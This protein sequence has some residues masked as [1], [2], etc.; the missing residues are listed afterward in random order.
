MNFTMVSIF[1]LGARVYS[2]PFFVQHS[3][4]AVRSFSDEVNRPPAPQAQN[5]L[6]SHPDDFELHE[7][8]TWDDGTGKFELHE[9]PKL[10]VS[11]K[12]LK[13]S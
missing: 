6:F 10:L 5:D 7:L 9:P 3:A 13:Q 1:D 8:G 2:R 12:S 4:Q 11:A